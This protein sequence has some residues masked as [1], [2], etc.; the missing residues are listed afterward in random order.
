MS[1][2]K[3]QVR[4]I[5]AREAGVDARG[6]QVLARGA[7]AATGAPYTSRSYRFPFALIAAH[8]AP[9]GV[10]LERVEPFDADFLE[11]I[12]TPR[13]RGLVPA[14]A[15]ALTSLWSSKEALAKALGDAVLYDPRRLD[16]PMFWPGGEAG[17]WRA[18]PLDVA[19]SHNG[20]LCWRSVG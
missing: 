15:R 11:S 10:D 17:P 20:W 9:V 18:V 4:L 12:C 8:E 16:S 2:S 7:A 5:D 13:E 19:P 14:H 6:L 1:G 3:P